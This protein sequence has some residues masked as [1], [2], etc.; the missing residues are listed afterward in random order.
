MRQLLDDTV[1][2]MGSTPLSYSTNG[3]NFSTASWSGR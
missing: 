3:T 1:Q 2:G